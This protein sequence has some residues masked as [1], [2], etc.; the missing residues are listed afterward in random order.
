MKMEKDKYFEI[1]KTISQPQRYL[2]PERGFVLKEKPRLKVLLIFPDIYEIGM[3]NYGFQLLYFLGNSIEDVQI[4]RGF[5]PWFDL[6]KKMKENSIPL[7]SIETQTPANQFSLI[8][9]TLPT[10]MHFTNLIYALDLS[11][12]PF[13]WKER[14]ERDP[15]IIAGGMSLSNPAPLLEILDVIAIGDGEILLP[16]ILNVF[17]EKEKKFE[18][19]EELSKIEGL[20]V[21]PL[22]KEKT[23]RV[24][25]NGLKDQFLFKPILPSFPSVHHRFTIE[26][27]R[28]C[29]WGCRFC[30]AG[31]WY[32]PY[33]EA[34]LEMTYNFL[35]ENA[36]SSGFTEVGLLSLSSSDIS[37][38]F[39]FCKNLIEFLKKYNISISMPSLRVSSLSLPL[40]EILQMVRKSSL[41]FAPETSENL[42]KKINKP[43]KDE[44]IINVLTKA[45]DMGW[46][47]VKF[48]FMLG[49]PF[50]EEEDLKSILNLIKEVKK[51]GFPSI[52]LNISNFVP[53]PWTPF[54][55]YKMP[56]LK[57]FY[58]KQNFLKKNL[59]IKA[60]FTNPKIS[61]I[62]ERLSRGG[63]VL[64]NVLIE[65]YKRGI[66]FDCWDEYLKY[67]EYLSALPEINEGE[68][69]WEEVIDFD[70]KKDFFEK[71]LE[72]AKRGEITIS[73]HKGCS[74]CIENCNVGRR[75]NEINFKIIEGEMGER[76]ENIIYKFYI[77]KENKAKYLSYTNY[78]NF[79][80]SFLI[81]KN[82]PLS[83][84]SGF[85]PHPIL[86]AE[87]SLPVGVESQEEIVYFNFF[88]EILIEKKEIS[89]GIKI[90]K[91]ERVEKKEKSK[92]ALFEYKGKK[93]ILKSHK[94]L[95]IKDYFNLKKIKNI[96]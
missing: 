83:F 93:I 80:S 61:Y 70:I 55:N 50:E 15:I 44:E 79:I 51:I 14:S 34:D 88:N 41:T 32:R 68:N 92:G 40:I 42:R 58:E 43:I 86:S 71:E 91:I 59:K 37:S 57:D 94:D 77:T 13:K 10:P 19:L 60:K 52:S 63:K 81:S 73:C 90:L 21:P 72:K 56:P 78:L 7:L 89:E 35:V 16:K 25:L 64:G 29:P 8:A 4:E 6:G 53:K 48:Y 22:R 17:L 3:A 65:L 26:I 27:M 38:I 76:K 84:S 47:N 36:P 62:E 20:I 23:K 5:L 33:R 54:Q 12:I 85:N 75:K 82:Y 28:G 24:V 69:P 74:L 66:F 30:Q 96:K 49:L 45:K 18:R 87:N 39:P 95:K 11:N 46:K 2:S 1:L 31:F 9:F 67:D